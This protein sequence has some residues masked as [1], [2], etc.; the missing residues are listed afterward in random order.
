ME[1]LGVCFWLVRDGVS[2]DEVDKGVG[3]WRRRRPAAG[4]GVGKR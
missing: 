2:R 3:E 1:S 4:T